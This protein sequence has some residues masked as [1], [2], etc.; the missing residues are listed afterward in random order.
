MASIRRDPLGRLT[1]LVKCKLS[2]RGFPVGYMELG[3]KLY[4]VEPSEGKKDGVIY[5]VKVTLL[6][7]SSRSRSGSRYNQERM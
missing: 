3:G 6:D 5:W 7:K 1:Q 2:K 4:K